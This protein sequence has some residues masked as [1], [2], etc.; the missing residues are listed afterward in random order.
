MRFKPLIVGA[1]L[2][3]V[4]VVT[5]VVMT[6]LPESKSHDE[7]SQIAVMAN[8]ISN[9][10]QSDEISQKTSEIAE[11]SRQ[12]DRKLKNSTDLRYIAIAVIAVVI[13]NGAVIYI[14][15]GI[16]KPFRKLERYADKIAAGEFDTALDYE[17]T[18]YF[19]K[20]TWAFDNM[21]REIIKARSCEREAIENNKTMIA[22]LSH[23]IKTPVAS[24]STYTEA[25]TN[26]L[27]DGRDEMY[28]YL[29]VISKKCAE[30]TALTNDMLTHA[31]S[32]LG[33]LKMQPEETDLY[34]ILSQAVD[35][36]DHGGSS[37]VIKPM[38]PAQVF[39]DRKRL[40]Q[41]AGNLIT[42]A[43]KYAGGRLDISITKKEG[44]FDIHFCDHGGG[45]PD[46]E[47]PF[48][49]DKF[50]R[51]SGSKEQSGSGLGLYIVRYIAQQSHGDAYAKN[52]DNGLEVIVSLPVF[53]EN[54]KS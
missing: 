44:R 20:F 19:G 21:R 10:S 48:L 23:D 5:A 47:L 17:R 29:G 1:L 16:I 51:G 35:E 34:T 15:V 38:F 24:I 41:L 3:L 52:N 6:F 8:E 22:T 9:L 4:I 31:I 50:Y 18:N 54:S 2:S 45:V 7:L 27:Y 42:N 12:C 53:S 14:W 33:A 25:L 28:E 37:K 13:V 30:L 40:L 39:A 49:F 11:L 46:E 43:K 36:Y 32:E 26:G